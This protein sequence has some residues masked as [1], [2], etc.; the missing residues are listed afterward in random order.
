MFGE[1]LAIRLST[2]GKD[3]GGFSPVGI[4][5]FFGTAAI[6][7]RVLGLGKV[8]MLNA[9]GFA[10]VRGA[11]SHQVASD[12]VSAIRMLFRWSCRSGIEAAMLAKRGLSGVKN[13]LQGPYGFFRLF[14]KTQP[15]LDALT[16]QLGRRFDVVRFHFKKYPTCGTTWAASEAAL[17]LVHK[18]DI[19]PKEIKRITVETAKFSNKYFR[20]FFNL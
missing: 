9:L 15:D 6:A 16:D 20:S 14:S 2:A 4:V 8:E 18:F 12:K 13:I 1:D 17:H 3:Y 7:A 19:N 5:M 10:F 11:G